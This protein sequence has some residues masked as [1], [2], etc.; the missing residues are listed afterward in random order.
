MSCTTVIGTTLVRQR[1]CCTQPWG[2]REE[3]KKLTKV[4]S[5][6][7][8]HAPFG[9]RRLIAN[10]YSRKHP[11]FKWVWSSL[12]CLSV[13]SPR[14]TGKY[15]STLRTRISPPT[16]LSLELSNKCIQTN[17]LVKD[18][19][20]LVCV[21]WKKLWTILLLVL[22]KILVYLGNFLFYWY[23]FHPIKIKHGEFV[24]LRSPCSSYKLSNLHRV[25][26]IVPL[27]RNLQIFFS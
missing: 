26:G 13:E 18:L 11:L 12:Q 19:L 6:Y 25:K 21:C 8:E 27:K 4:L 24:I 1:Q 7:W 22:F 16:S 9:G 14:R 2:G 5:N 17:A 3:G 15:G 20:I 23:Y 10:N